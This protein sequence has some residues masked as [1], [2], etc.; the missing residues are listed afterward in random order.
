MPFDIGQRVI[1][2]KS[3]A[4]PQGAHTALQLHECGD[5]YPMSEVH[6][7]W[8]LQLKEDQLLYCMPL[9]ITSATMPYQLYR[10]RSRLRPLPSMVSSVAVL[11]SAYHRIHS[12]L[13][14]SNSKPSASKAALL[15]GSPCA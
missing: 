6:V 1:L 8:V 15:W 5:A 11:S 13:A 7:A 4:F 9:S 10:Y 14:S 3:G 2:C 12:A